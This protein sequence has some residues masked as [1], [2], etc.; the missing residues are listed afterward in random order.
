MKD[1][2]DEREGEKVEE[3]AAGSSES[4]EPRKYCLSWKEYPSVFNKEFDVMRKEENFFDLT[5]VCEDDFQVGVHKLVLSAASEFFKAIL[6]RNQHEHPL[7]YL[8]GVANK[9]LEAILDFIYTGE[10]EVAEKDLQS[11][12]ETAN[13]LKIKGL[14]ES[15]L[16]KE[17]VSSPKQQQEDLKKIPTKRVR[18]MRDCGEIAK[19]KIEVDRA[20]ENSE[21]DTATL[22][23]T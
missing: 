17:G 8:S 7:I 10:T 13:N 2:G 21:V 14:S 16:E 3:G 20:S 6:R 19:I 5:L 9:D 18:P 22:A 15:N 4:S 1:R 12:L 11:L 23:N